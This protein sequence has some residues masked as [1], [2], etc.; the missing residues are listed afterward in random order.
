MGGVVAGLSRAGGR[1]GG[2]G[3]AGLA[4]RCAVEGAVLAAG[5]GRCSCSRQPGKHVAGNRKHPLTSFRTLCRTDTP[6]RQSAIDG[7]EC[8]SYVF[9]FCSE[10]CERVLW[11]SGPGLATWSSPQAD[12][13]MPVSRTDRSPDGDVNCLGDET[14]RAIVQSH[15]TATR[16]V[17]PERDLEIPGRLFA[18]GSE[19]AASQTLGKQEQTTTRRPRDVRVVGT[20]CH[21][22]RGEGGMLRIKCVQ[23]PEHVA[24]TPKANGAVSRVSEE[25]RGSFP[26]QAATAEAFE[27]QR[28]RVGLPGRPAG[29]R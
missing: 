3:V 17:T 7:Q 21:P 8:P 5:A 2:L 27:L 12:R 19:V 10:T 6:V 29:S 4:G 26:W 15:D 1:V 24:P 13:L 22:C 11:C 9:P 28:C 25:D 23:R 16:M 18:I 14:R 20:S